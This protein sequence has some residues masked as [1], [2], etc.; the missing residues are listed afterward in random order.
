MNKT[1][2][3]M[4]KSEDDIRVAFTDMHSW[5]EFVEMFEDYIAFVSADELSCFNEKFKDYIRNLGGFYVIYERGWFG[6]GL[7]QGG[8]RDEYQY[9]YVDAKDFLKIAKSNINI[10]PSNFEKYIP[11]KPKSTI[12]VH[13]IF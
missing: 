7:L 3:K 5:F 12:L 13:A 2:L 10:T 6:E 9:L 4:F 8:L 11:L 1:L